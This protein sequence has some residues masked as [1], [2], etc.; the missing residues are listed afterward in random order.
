MRH[1]DWK[2]EI[3]FIFLAP[4]IVRGHCFLCVFCFVYFTINS[5]CPDAG[6]V[7]ARPEGPSPPPV[8]IEGQKKL[9][10]PIVDFVLFVT[11]QSKIFARQNA[12]L[13]LYGILSGRVF[14]FLL[15]RRSPR[16]Y[17]SPSSSSLFLTTT[18][19]TCNRDIPENQFALA[20]SFAFSVASRGRRSPRFPLPS[21]S[22]RWFSLRAPFLPPSHNVALL[23]ALPVKERTFFCFLSREILD[24]DNVGF[25]AD[26]RARERER[27]RDGDTVCISEKWFVTLD[28]PQ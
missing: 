13:L 14:F 6:P 4:L 11:E 17:P 3:K 15:L 5:V 24:G 27:E 2:H 8:S 21:L 18:T 7:V 1:V 20:G 26:S 9:G 19:T 23:R 28:G 10:P 16:S 25:A 22:P 12:A